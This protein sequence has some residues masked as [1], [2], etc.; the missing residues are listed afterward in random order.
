[1]FVALA[2]SSG[3]PREAFPVVGVQPESTFKHTGFHLRFLQIQ[4]RLL[5][6]LYTAIV[7]ANGSTGG[8]SDLLILSSGIALR[9]ALIAWLGKYGSSATCVEINQ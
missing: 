7:L 1:M 9:A 3:A 6:R 4:G 5:R 2:L 8:P